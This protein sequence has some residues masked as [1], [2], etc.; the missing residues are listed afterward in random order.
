MSV[1]FYRRAS[2]IGLT[3]VRVSH[4]RIY[5]IGFILIAFAISSR[6]AQAS[7]LVD[8]DIASVQ[9]T[10]TT[11]S[12]TTVSSTI[13]S[14]SLLAGINSKDT[15]Y[16]GAYYLGD[17]F[18]NVA[19]TTTT[20]GIADIGMGVKWYMDKNHFMSLFAGYAYSSKA[21][22]TQGATNEEWSGSSLLGKFSIEPDFGKISLGVSI[23]YYSATYTSKTVS[24]TTS[25]VSNANTFLV[26]SVGLTYRW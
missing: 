11:P 19:T 25:S 15:F 6:F 2:E 23:L 18:S 8:L 10:L 17:T 9:N 5:L 21:T 20:F 3:E 22:Y 14:L 24:N 7:A 16:F 1:Q 26:P 4:L 13:Y 12:V